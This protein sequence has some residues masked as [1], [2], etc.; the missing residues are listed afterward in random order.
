M[1]DCPHTQSNR[2]VFTATGVVCATEE[3]ADAVMEQM[4]DAVAPVFRT[5]YEAFQDQGLGTPDPMLVARF[6]ARQ[7]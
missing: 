7:N 2:M 5:L 1:N 4:V 3:F 6:V